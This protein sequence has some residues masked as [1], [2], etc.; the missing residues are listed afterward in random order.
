MPST[1][2][3]LRFLVPSVVAVAAFFIGRWS[4][5]PDSPSAPT[6]R[7]PAGPTLTAHALPAVAPVAPAVATPVEESAKL[8]KLVARPVDSFAA[9]EERQ[10]LIEQWAAVDPR[11]AIAFVRTQMKG[12]RQAQAMAAVIS[13]WGKNDPDSA[14]NWV[15]TEMPTATHHFDTLLEVFGRN[16]PSV[17][18][19]YAA[20][21]AAAHPEASLEVHLAALLGVT[22]Q[23][24]F[25]GARALVDGE[26]ALDPVVR[27]NLNNFIAGQWARFAPTEAAAWVMS[28]PPGPQ[29]DQAMIGLGESWSDV[30]PAQATAFA[31]DL[32]AG[33]SRTLAMRQAI[34]KWVEADPTAAR[35]WVLKTDRHEDFDQAVNAIATQNNFMSREPA[36]AM[37]WAEGIFDDALRAKS[38]ST[39]LYNWFPS[40][41]A[42]A[43][44]Y[45]QA[46]PEFTPE[47]R[48]ELLKNLRPSPSG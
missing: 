45:L 13:I 25:A 34:S 2:S 22:Y 23:G 11:G 17:A 36:R 32:P 8:G 42:A 30:D 47:K 20:T 31:A 16:S 39:I 40:D 29:R 1:S 28:L 7:A 35:A 12:D 43:T 9:E 33:E 15:S 44:A 37:H 14:W 10:H 19:H 4:T 38:V 46:S 24:N 6:P 41:P 26:A 3:S 27:A 5:R 18:A 48:A 21:Y